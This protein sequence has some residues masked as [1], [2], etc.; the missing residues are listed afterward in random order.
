MRRILVVGSKGFI[1]SHVLGYYNCALDFEVWG[2]DVATDYAAK[3]YFTIDAVNADFDE[4]FKQ[5]SFDICV[6]CA[7]AASVPDSVRSPHRDF[8]LN[9]A[10]V[11]KL[12]DSIRRNA[13]HCKFLNL[14]SAAVYGNPSRIPVQENAPIKPIS[15]YGWHKYQSEIICR[16]F[17]EVYG[18]ATCSAR[19]FS[20]YG[21]GLQKQLFWDWYQKIMTDKTVEFFGTGLESRDFIYIDDLVHALDQIITNGHFCGEAINVANG[22]EVFI[23][24]VAE[25]FA[26]ILANTFTYHF[27]GAIRKGDPVNWS[28]DISTLMSLGY[29]RKVGFEEGLQKY[30]EWLK[31]KR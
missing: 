9:T 5:I 18:I 19:I 2:A 12:L 8:Q 15:P 28:A 22:E 10:V 21:V 3:K 24:D 11:F 1:G 4:V 23:R 16:E 6:N 30:L 7:G 27:N 13:P 29:V 17:H 26:R 14:S 20:A 25:S 31:G